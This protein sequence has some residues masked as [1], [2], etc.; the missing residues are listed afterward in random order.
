[1]RLAQRVDRL[2]TETAFEVLATVK[3][4]EAEGKSIISFAIGEP[5]F[6]TPEN[7]KEAGCRA[8][9][10]NETHYGPSAGIMPMRETIAKYIAETRGI[11][12]TPEN[13][14]VTPGAKPIIFHSILACVDPGDE[15]IYPNP[16]FPIYESMIRFVGAKPVPLPLVEEKNFSFDVDHLRSLVT[17][18]TK[19]II[20]NSPQNPTGG[21][22]SKSDLEAVAELAI[23]NDLWVFSDEIYSR[24]VFDSD[25]YSITAI[26]GMQERTI[27]LDGFSKT[28]AMTGWRLGYGVMNPKLA[29]ALAR[30]ETNAESCTATFTQW[31]G[32]EALTGPQDAAEAMAL[33]FRQRRDLIVEGL[34][35]IE[36]ITC[37]NPGG[38]FY[39]YPN[40]TGACKKLGLADSRALQKYLLH[41]AGVAVLARSCFGQRNVGEDQEYVRFSYATSREQIKEGLA[42]IKKAIEG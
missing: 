17:E 11:R 16:G 37:L 20:I 7:I 35:Q 34:N 36:G 40:V 2:G 31:A 13:V 39:V 18:R 8:I 28:Y 3:Q 33:E 5:D 19:M 42:R 4:L 1:M 30:L 29:Q 21:V 25:F 10:N 12:V 22:L 38:A 15:V 6:E 9:Q 14:V 32:I 41:E 26:P 27:I 24:I 23:A